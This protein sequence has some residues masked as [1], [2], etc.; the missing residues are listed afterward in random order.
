[1]T[2]KEVEQFFLDWE[3]VKRISDCVNKSNMRL[4]QLDVW[5]KNESHREAIN[6]EERVFKGYADLLTERLNG[7]PF[8]EWHD[9]NTK[10]KMLMRRR[11][12]A[13]SIAMKVEEQITNIIF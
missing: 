1:M 8:K 7:K 4:T 11:N 13:L 6:K 12:S 5:N 10:L 2:Q 3:N 9:M